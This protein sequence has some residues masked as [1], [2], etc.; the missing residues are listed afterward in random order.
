MKACTNYSVKRSFLWRCD[1]KE[2]KMHDALVEKRKLYAT[3]LSEVCLL[4]QHRLL[5]FVSGRVQRKRQHP[6]NN[7][8]KQTRLEVDNLTWWKIGLIVII[9]PVNIRGGANDLYSRWP[10]VKFG[11]SEQHKQL[12]FKSCGAFEVKLWPS[13][14]FTLVC[15]SKAN[16]LSQLGSRVTCYWVERLKTRC[17]AADLTDLPAYF[18]LLP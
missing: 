17:C 14:S 3:G 13:N 7:C 9:M 1:I 10:V 16:A 2:K 8:W 11:L 12:D 4:R 6:K 5:R 18:Q 15:S